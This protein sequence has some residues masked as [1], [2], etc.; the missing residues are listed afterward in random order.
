M[1]YSSVYLEKQ[2]AEYQG[3][4]VPEIVVTDIRL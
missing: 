2:I 3:S 1:T 4:L